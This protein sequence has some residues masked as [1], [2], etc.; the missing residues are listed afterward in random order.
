M[1]VDVHNPSHQQGKLGRATDDEDT[2]IV[3]SSR[4][5]EPS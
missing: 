5:K 3:S 2:I 1:H 4:P